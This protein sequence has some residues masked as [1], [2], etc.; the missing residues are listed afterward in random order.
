[1]GNKYP[2]IRARLEAW[3]KKQTEAVL[4]DRVL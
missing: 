3:R 4:E 2:E 1:L